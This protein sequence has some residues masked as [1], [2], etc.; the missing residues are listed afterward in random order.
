MIRL[1]LQQRIEMIRGSLRNGEQVVGDVEQKI[2]NLYEERHRQH[3]TLAADVSATSGDTLYNGDLVGRKE[4]RSQR[5][6]IPI[7]STALSPLK[8]TAIEYGIPAAYRLHGG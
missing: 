7:S 6:D 2:S 8:T 5:E 3:V 1:G 4:E